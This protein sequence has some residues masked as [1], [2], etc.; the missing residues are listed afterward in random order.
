MRKEKRLSER[1]TKKWRGNNI[2]LSQGMQ[3]PSS[4]H[5]TLVQQV[6]NYPD[7]MR[8]QSLLKHMF[9]LCVVLLILVEDVANN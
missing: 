5:I 2:P 4:C 7:T 1:T 6:Y 3:H 9:Y 8:E